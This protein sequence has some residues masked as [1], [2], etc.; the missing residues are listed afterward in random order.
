MDKI[1]NTTPHDIHYI[2]GDLRL[3]FSKASV[4][5]R[6]SEEKANPKTFKIGNIYVAIIDPPVYTGIDGLPDDQSNTIIVSQLVGEYLKANPDKY[7][8]TVVGP[9]TGP[10]FVVRDDKGAIIGTKSF[11]LYKN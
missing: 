4:Q 2:N 3:T 9:H 6:L 8:G 7:K 10:A 5:I 11:I 1:I